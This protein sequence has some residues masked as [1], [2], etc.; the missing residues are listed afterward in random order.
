MSSPRNEDLFFSFVAVPCTA[1][2]D[3]YHQ[4]SNRNDKTI[5]GKFI[6][7][8]N[9]L[10]QEMTKQVVVDRKLLRKLSHNR[11]AILLISENNNN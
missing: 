10:L 8:R 2:E 5:G 11:S 1:V 4:Y 9:L 7:P 3:R 6:I